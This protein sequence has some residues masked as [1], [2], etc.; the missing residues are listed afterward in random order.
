MDARLSAVFYTA[1]YIIS[2]T[3]MC[4]RWKHQQQ[5]QQRRVPISPCFAAY[6]AK[7]SATRLS[8][9]TPG[10]GAISSS[11]LTKRSNSME[12]SKFFLTLCTKLPPPPPPP[13]SPTK[14]AHTVARYTVGYAWMYGTAMM[15]GSFQVATGPLRL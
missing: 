8:A 3:L 15:S 1:V 2:I 14:H 12:F 4:S 10:S 5:Q 9:T 11:K 7:C 6:G 13:H